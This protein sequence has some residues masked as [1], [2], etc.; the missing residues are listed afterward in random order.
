MRKLKLHELGR[1]TIEEFKEA[2]K[3]KLVVVLDNIRSGMNVGSFFRTADAFAVEKLY[4]CGI[5]SKPPHREINKTAIG[6]DHSV[7]WKYDEDI[8]STISKLKREG[9]T[10]VAIEQIDKS[11]MLQD[12]EAEENI[13]YALV[14]GNEV[15]GISEAILPLVD[16]CL[17]IPQSG[18]KHSFNVAVSGGIIL[19]HFLRKKM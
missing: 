3:N 8:Y 9:Y 7:D 6:A 12:F 17:E 5:T 14:F 16:L 4:L 13:K 1:K 11:I 2:E 15:E 19:W 18:T 10:I